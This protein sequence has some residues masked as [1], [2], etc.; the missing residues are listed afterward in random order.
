MSILY[1]AYGS[2]L[3]WSRMRER[4]P[5]A[6]MEAVAFLEHHRLACNKQGRDGSAKANLVRAPGDRVWGVVY[7]IDKAD[8]ALL[9]QFEAGYQRIEVEVGTTAGGAH[10]ASTYRSDRIAGDPT[11][12]D[13]Y[14]GLILEGAREHGLPE[15][16]LAV[17]EA[18]PARPDERASPDDS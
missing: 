6:R 18:L 16:Y 13:W 8:L 3:K 1:F 14:R 15:E 4:V 11:P 17:L 2:N 12:L 7:R 9:D 5:S 10:R